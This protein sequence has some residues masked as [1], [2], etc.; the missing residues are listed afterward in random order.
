MLGLAPWAAYI[1]A[2]SFWPGW[3]Q[4]GETWTQTIEN[5]TLL[6]FPAAVFVA[7]FRYGLLDIENLVRRS[8]VYGVVSALVLIL[9]LQAADGGAALVHGKPG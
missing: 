3:D 2:A 9:A 7:I 1:L 8:L 4:L 5:L 6:A